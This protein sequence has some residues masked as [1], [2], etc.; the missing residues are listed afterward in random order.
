MMRLFS[1]YE[2]LSVM[3]LV[4]GRD[5]FEDFHEM[6]AIGN[7]STHNNGRAAGTLAK[8]KNAPLKLSG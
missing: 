4:T 2:I 6:V 3:I 1:Y 5:H 7:Y 8:A